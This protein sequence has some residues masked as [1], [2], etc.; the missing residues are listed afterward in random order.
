VG[1]VWLGLMFFCIGWHFIYQRKLAESAR[2]FVQGYC[3]EHN[4]Q[5]LSIAKLKSRIVFDKKQGLTW[6]NYYTFEFSGDRESR[7]EGTLII[8]GAK[9]KNIDLPVYRVE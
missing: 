5:F 3:D 8:Q 1:T 2:R 7:Y 4:I 6:Q 9:V